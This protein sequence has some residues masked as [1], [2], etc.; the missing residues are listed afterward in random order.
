MTEK[1][2]LEL[3]DLSVAYRVGRR[4]RAVLRN[5]NLTIKAGEAYG[6]VGESGCGKSTVA[7]SVVRY[8]PRNGSITG[9]S[10]A[11]DGQD[12]MR[13]DAEALRRARAESVSM[14]YQD[15][16]KALNPSLRIGRQL[17]EIFELAGVSGRAAADKAIAMLNRVRISDPASVMQRYPHQ[18]SG[19]MQQRV[20]IA[21]ALA[22]DP[23]MLILDEPTTGLDATVEA[24]VLDLIAQLRREL[25]ASIL[26]IS[27]NLAVV[28][29]MCDR[30]GVLYAGML[31]EEGPTK[32][33]F[34]DP[35]HP[36]T[37]ALLR[38]LP[39][40]GQRKDQGRLDTIPGFLPG[41]GA[42]IVGCAFADRCALA[43]ERCRKEPPPLYEISDD[44]GGIRLS[45]CHYHDKAQSLPRATP[46]EIAAAQPKQAPP[47]LQ[48]EGLS[49]TYASHGRPLKAVKDVSVSLRPGETLGL[50]GESGSGKTTFARLLL[51]L[52][53]PDDG[54][55]IELE[56][57]K[58]APRLASRSEDQVKALQIVFQNPDSALNRSHSIRHILSRAL[59]RLGGLTGKTLDTRLEELVR[60]VR[61]TDRHLSVKPRQ[62]SGGLKQRVAIARAFA[63]DPRIVVCDEPTSALDVSVQA[64]ILN[65]LADLQSKQDVSYI[66]ISHDLGVVRYLADKIAVLYLGRIMEFGPSEAVFSGPHHPYTEALLSAVPKLDRAESSRIRLDGEIPSAA[67][68]PTGCVFHTRCPRKIGAICET[69]EP[70]LTEAQ[71]G[72]TIRCHIPYL[73]LA[74]LQKQK[75]AEPA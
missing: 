69:R 40:G 29:N 71:P 37:V 53:P 21:M 12:I 3:K 39:R 51:G 65:L 11:L 66:F 26:F 57:K 1:N 35:R 48:V 34:N 33:V 5:V 23:S 4:N 72:H 74:R 64:A 47:V 24:E 45:R 13:L 58:L 2:A 56:G 54:S 43:T 38:C 27:H 19:G 60:S 52:V 63:G 25:S 61:L 8:L 9:G 28:S 50:V 20:A 44:H 16:G 68:P 7:L 73:E 62:L 6:L 14:V 41:I 22:N 18:L 15:P 10:I 55:S 17:T 31:V 75:E 70:E 59:K 49:K 42:T 46:A 67:N 36:Y 30:V 32:D